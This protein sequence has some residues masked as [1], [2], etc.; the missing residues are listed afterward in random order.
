M[1]F[2]NELKKDQAQKKIEVQYLRYFLPLNFLHWR[3]YSKISQ[4]IATRRKKK[5]Q[6]YSI[7]CFL[8]EV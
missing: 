5:T 2:Y 3:P 7:P 6:L 1:E 8:M 4:E